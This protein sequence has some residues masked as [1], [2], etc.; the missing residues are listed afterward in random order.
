MP[1]Y[2]AVPATRQHAE[3]VAAGLADEDALEL[4]SGG[5]PDA[6]TGIL[7]SMT[8]SAAPLAWLAP[9]G[10]PLCVY[11]VVPTTLL[12]PI[13]QPWMLAHRDLPKHGRPFLRES[14]QW[15]AQQQAQYD[16]LFNYVGSWHTRSVRWL[17]WLGFTIEPAISVQHA[18]GLWHKV[19]WAKDT[20]S[21]TVK[22]SNS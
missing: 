19:W 17:G 4:S 2:R 16:W 1:K 20:N 12:P 9:D 13:G 8:A 22:Q 15:T 7:S 11:G 10:Q 18:T 21:L 6:L 14:R 3:A 5:C